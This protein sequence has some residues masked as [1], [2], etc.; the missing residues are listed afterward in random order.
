MAAVLKMDKEGLVQLR[1]KDDG[2]GGGRFGFALDVFSRTG[3]HQGLFSIQK[4]E[5]LEGVVDVRQTGQR[6]AS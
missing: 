4:V 5:A 3:F 2:G 1:S 6:L